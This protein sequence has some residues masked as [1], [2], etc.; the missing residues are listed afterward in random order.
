MSVLGKKQEPHRN[1]PPQW[2]TSLYDLLR[3]QTESTALCD[4]APPQNKTALDQT[5]RDV[6]TPYYNSTHEGHTGESRGK[7]AIIKY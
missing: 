2:A 3:R 6:L 7:E 4:D 5:F 1:M